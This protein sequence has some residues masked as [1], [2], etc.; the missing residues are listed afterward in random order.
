M[1]CIY[2][3]TPLI[4]LS[5]YSINTS[6]NLSYQVAVYEQ[7]HLLSVSYVSGSTCVIKNIYE[8]TYKNIKSILKNI[9]KYI[10]IYI[11]IYIYVYI[12]MC[13]IIIF[14]CVCI[15]YKCY[16]P[17]CYCIVELISVTVHFFF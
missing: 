1:K 5:L 4:R 17:A 7:I 6:V 13:F 14:Y 2:I 16:K 3:C 8:V 9:K 10:Y 15:D 11:Y 12:H